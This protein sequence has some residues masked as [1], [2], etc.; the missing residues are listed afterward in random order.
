MRFFVLICFVL[1]STSFAGNINQMLGHHHI[2]CDDCVYDK[3]SNVLSVYINKNKKLMLNGFTL[4]IFKPDYLPDFTYQIALTEN[5]SSKLSLACFY[6]NTENQSFTYYPGKHEAVS[7]TFK[8]DYQPMI[9]DSLANLS[10]EIDPHAYVRYQKNST[11]HTLSLYSDNPAQLELYFNDELNTPIFSLYSNK[12]HAPLNFEGIAHTQNPIPI[13]LKSFTAHGDKKTFTPIVYLSDEHSLGYL[14]IK[15]HSYLL[16]SAHNSSGLTLN[17]KHLSASQLLARLITK[18][19][20]IQK[21][22]NHYPDLRQVDDSGYT[23]EHLVKQTGRNYYMIRIANEELYQLLNYLQ[24]WAKDHPPLPKLTKIF[25][26]NSSDHDLSSADTQASVLSFS[27]GSKK[28]YTHIVNQEINFSPSMGLPEFFHELAHAYHNILTYDQSSYFND[29]WQK[30]NDEDYKQLVFGNEDLYFQVWNHDLKASAEAIA[31]YSKILSG[32]NLSHTE[33]QLLH[34]LSKRPFC[35]YIRPYGNFSLQEDVATYVEEIKRHPHPQWWS[36][37]VNAEQ[38]VCADKYQN[39]LY[40]LKRYGFISKSSY[41]NI[42][43]TNNSN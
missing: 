1:L 23:N 31:V 24:S 41:E 9:H 27:V 35:G 29:L 14:D 10:L 5:C 6:N 36:K 26:K 13:Q 11:Q 22:Q 43:S 32:E 20:I 28:V 40:L 18:S 16:N 21:L 34:D 33:N 39:K 17:E 37:L 8:P 25:I 15:L 38:N 3:Y 7:F 12:L 30:V 19:Y 2:E 42:F 4:S